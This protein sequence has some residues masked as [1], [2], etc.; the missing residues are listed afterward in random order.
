[1]FTLAVFLGRLTVMDGTSLSLVW[2]AA[3]VA[4][5]WFAVQRGAG[6]RTLDVTALAL[7]TFTVNALTGAAPLLAMCFVAANLVQVAVFHV[8]LGRWEPALWGAGGTE[9]LTGSRQL[10][11][12]L[13]AALVATAAGAL[14]GPTSV[15]VLTGHWS[16]LTTAVWMTRN[17]VSVVLI[18]GLGL[19]V[20]YL[21]AA[22]RRQRAAARAGGREPVTLPFQ[23]LDG[24]RRLE[25]ALLLAASAG[26][27]LLA[28]H[29]LETLPIAFPLIALTVWAALRFDT[30]IVVVHDFA[31][32]V[33]AVLFT[34]SGHGPFAFVASDSTRAL[35]VQGFVG[36]V[37]V[38]GLALAL[39]RDER[40]VLLH[41]VRRQAAE[42]VE[43]TGHVEVLARVARQLYTS[44]DVRADI[45]A[46]AREVSG[47]DMVYLLEPDGLGNLVSTA[48]DGVQV[49]PLTF[50]LDGEPS[51]TVRAFRG[52]KLFFVGDVAQRTDASE[53]VARGLGVAAAAWQPVLTGAEQAIGVLALAWHRPVSALPGHVPAMLETLASEAAA[54]IE[55]GDLL[56]R[57]ATAAG[58]D[59]LTQ[60]ANRGRWDEA[61]AAEIARAT[62]YGMPLTFALVDLDHFKRYNDTRGHLAGDALLRDFAA[63]AAGQLRDVDTL[64]RWGGEEFAL[65]LPGC[66]AA[67]ALA[68][69]ERIRACVPHAQTCTVGIAQ[70]SS[71]QSA[72]D[73]LHAADRALYRGKSIGRNVSVIA[74]ADTGD[75]A[76]AE[77]RVNEVRTP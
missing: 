56:V 15:G 40:E 59:A 75:D 67:E 71:G 17:T 8:L 51:L 43:R 48:A 58:R 74:G 68:V 57:L 30:T 70:W 53:R 35:V 60:L 23:R 26:G 32:G 66:T 4:T 27:Y 54:A 34:L 10:A 46:A 14:L 49:P 2:P 3:G 11:R 38:I 13:L 77:E 22:H 42:A 12:V 45:C 9:P 47:A 50:N 21:L 37:A 7:I 76:P 63:A 1:M 55:R 39:G 5:L 33:A 31:V 18:V 69:A 64:A 19:R 72:D 16:W 61:A 65:A 28:F 6:T 41:K 20:G 36:L 29:V 24:A 73:A 44:E 25:L 62:R 52:G